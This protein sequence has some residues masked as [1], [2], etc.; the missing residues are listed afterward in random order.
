MD[1]SMFKFIWR[2]SSTQQL[3]ALALTLVSFPFLYFSLDLPKTIINKAIDTE[4]GKF[5][6]HLFAFDIDL[7]GFQF[8]W[9]GILMDQL[10]YLFTLCGIFLALVFINGGFKL[11]INTYKGV[12][13]ERQVLL[14]APVCLTEPD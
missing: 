4:E 9:D 11:R 8:G 2:Y 7:F 13:A 14:D 1:R 5:P 10:P 6:A 12:M 3:T